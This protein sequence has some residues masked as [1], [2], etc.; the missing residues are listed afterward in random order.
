MGIEFQNDMLALGHTVVTGRKFTVIKES[1][2]T[3]GVDDNGEPEERN[4]RSITYV[5]KTRKCSIFWG[6]TSAEV[7]TK[8]KNNTPDKELAV[9]IEVL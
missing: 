4:A 8:I 1:E 3:E 7:K 6:A 2:K 5:P 9:A